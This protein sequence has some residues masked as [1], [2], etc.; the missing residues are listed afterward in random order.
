ML[1]KKDCSI[2][3]FAKIST[4]DG[5]EI[6]VPLSY[7]WKR[8][9]YFQ[10]LMTLDED[11]NPCESS[12]DVDLTAEEFKEVIE[13]LKQGVINFRGLKEIRRIANFTQLG[14][15]FR[16]MTN[17]NMNQYYCPSRNAVNTGF[18]EHF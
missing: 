3:G 1:R 9:M 7:L 14:L 10:N 8:S 16:L 17:L 11:G 5:K 13:F 6:E 15:L 12:F 4:I 18:E 2:I